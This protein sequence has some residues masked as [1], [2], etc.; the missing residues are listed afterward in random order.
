VLFRE[1]FKPATPGHTSCFYSAGAEEVKELKEYRQALIS[2]AV[3]G[4]MMV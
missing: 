3:T 1:K 4:K 2:E